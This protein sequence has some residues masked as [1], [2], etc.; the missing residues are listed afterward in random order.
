MNL[1]M[2]GLLT[3]GVAFVAAIMLGLWGLTISLPFA[4]L[5]S[6]WLIVKEK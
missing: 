3:F 6:V 4:L 1:V 5:L 2:A